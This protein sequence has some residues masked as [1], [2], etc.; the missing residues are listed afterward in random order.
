MKIVLYVSRYP[1]ENVLTPP[2]LQYLAGYLIAKKLVKEENILFA[3]STEEIIEFNPDI[4][5]IG[6]VSQSFNDA[7]NVAKKVRSALPDCGVVLGGYHVS[8]LPEMLPNVVDI[9]V[10]GEGEI[11]FAEIVSLRKE[12]KKLELNSLRQIKG[13]CFREENG[14]VTTTPRRPQIKDIDSLPLPFRRLTYGQEWPYLFTARGCPF[15]CMYCASQSFWERYRPHSANYVVNEIERLIKD[16]G[17]SSIYFVDD[18]FIAPK[19]RLREIM[20]LLEQKGL[21]GKVRF[22]GFVRVNLVDEEVIYILKKMGFVEIRF[23]META[24]DRL[25]SVIKDQPFTIKQAE[26]VIGL[27]NKYEIPICASFMFGIPGEEESDIRASRDFLRKHK[28]RFS[29]SGFYLMQPIPGTSLWNDCLRKGIVSPTMD[30]SRLRLDFIKK[31]FDF[32]KALYINA[33]KIHPRKFRKIMK[34]IH[35]EFIDEK[36][37]NIVKIHILKILD[38]MLQR[39]IQGINRCILVFGYKINRILSQNSKP[40][41]EKL[42]DVI[43]EKDLKIYMGC[44]E[45]TREGYIGCDKRRLPNVSIVCNAW[46]LSR[47]CTGVGEIYSRHMLEH[48]T[49]IQVKA[50]LCDWMKALAVG[51]KVNIIVPNMDFHI[52]QWRRAVWDEASWEQKWSDARHAFAGFWGWQRET[53]PDD[54]DIN[55]G[56]L[57]WDVHKSG[58]NKKSLSFLLKRSGFSNIKCE[59]VDDVHVV[60]HAVKKDAEGM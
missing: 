35:K 13:V 37:Q 51:G 5:G 27:C 15:H 29:I 31:D 26:E 58:Y 57:C 21:L 33:D 34:E 25:L 8:S 36:R 16:F 43:K 11:T 48:L 46:E 19:K 44:G 4:L 30:F 12:S 45:E 54:Q 47:H 6:S 32:D 18:L 17:V 56:S 28:V 53:G 24:S 3:N 38:N 39:I 52:E 55:D 1:E 9:G 41:R 50:T 7:I 14:Q 20:V 49:L 42:K 22:K 60:A 10:I 2:S 23:G 59:V 40:Q